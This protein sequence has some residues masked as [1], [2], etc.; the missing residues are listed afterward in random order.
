MLMDDDPV[1]IA[2]AIR[3]ARKCI[4]IVYEN[5][6]FAIGIKLICLVLIL[7]PVPYIPLQHPNIEDG[8]PTA[9]PCAVCD[10]PSA[11]DFEAE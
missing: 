4:R 1:K 6:Y 9:N 8:F 5:I 3:I 11:S 2:A 7:I 10:F